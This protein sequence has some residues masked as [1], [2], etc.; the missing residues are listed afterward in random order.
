M[1]TL[2]AY[3]WIG[4]LSVHN[5]ACQADEQEVSSAPKS[6]AVK[7]IANSD[8]VSSEV[9]AIDLSQPP[10]SPF[11][12]PHLE[13]QAILADGQAKERCEAAFAAV[14]AGSPVVEYRNLTLTNGN[15]GD[16]AHRF[17][18]YD[19]YRP[20]DQGKSI[21]AIRG[22]NMHSPVIDFT[23]DD[24][25]ATKNGGLAVNVRNDGPVV[26]IE[27]VH[28]K[29]GY[30]GW[31]ESTRKIPRTDAVGELRPKYQ[32]AIRSLG[33]G[34][35][36]CV[37]NVRITGFYYGIH[38][39]DH[40]WIYAKNVVVE[41]SGDGGFFAFDGGKIHAESTASNFAADGSRRLGFGYVAETRHWHF[42][43]PQTMK[44]DPPSVETAPHNQV[45]CANVSLKNLG[46]NDTVVPLDPAQAI[47][48]FKETG[49]HLKWS[50]A[51][52]LGPVRQRLDAAGAP[53][54]CRPEAYATPEE[55]QKCRIEQFL[56]PREDRHQCLM[57]TSA[58][59]PLRHRSYIYARNSY[60]NGNLMGGFFANYGADLDVDGAYAYGSQ[61]RRPDGQGGFAIRI[62]EN[63]N[64]ASGEVCDSN[65]KVE[66]NAWA[67]GQYAEGLGFVARYGSRM[68]ANRAV[69]VDNLIGFSA[70][71]GSSLAAREARAWHNRSYGFHAVKSG[72]ID[73]VK[74]LAWGNQRYHLAVSNQDSGIRLDGLLTPKLRAGPSGS[75]LHLMPEPFKQPYD[76]FGSTYA[77]TVS[78]D[79]STC[80]FLNT[81][82]QSKTPKGL[83]YID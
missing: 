41:N 27:N 12:Y 82:H 50:R 49:K 33:D 11:A 71:R 81:I 53:T 4:V 56:A 24:G 45:Y 14:A 3:F 35:L 1:K 65:G 44:L 57:G 37:R 76:I 42:I 26:V 61:A 18:V 22:V 10:A 5:Y 55:F 54:T 2:S 32:S 23:R 17:G 25:N 75:R 8:L 19:F 47:A 6:S 62:V 7:T 67:A 69:A 43:R 29:G 51:Q 58:K 20:L 13:S 77:V 34:N 31:S 15:Y 74:A 9:A 16:Q 46:W 38:A 39:E 21:V 72:V 36:V 52:L 66:P 80:D 73:A 68:R 40:A 28:L 78:G 48:N 83:F 59:I 60:A 30:H 79:T 64:V 63:G 70:W